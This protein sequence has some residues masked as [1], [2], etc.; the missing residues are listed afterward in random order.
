M[1][2]GLASRIFV[3]D[4]EHVIASTLAAIL[5][6]NGF[7]ARY[8]VRPLEALAAT[9]V[10]VPDLLI[11]DVLMPCM[12]GIDLAIHMRANHPRCKILLLSGQAHTSDLLEKARRH[13][14]HFR[15]L[16]KPVLPTELLSEIEEI[17]DAPLCRPMGKSRPALHRVR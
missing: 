9:Q 1:Y 17:C 13:G 15:L 7:S 10:D 16:V 3:V 8:F 4:D 5:E 12:S 11:S 14:H 2:Q 6:L